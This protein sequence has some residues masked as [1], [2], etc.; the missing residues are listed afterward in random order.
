MTTDRPPPEKAS[1]EAQETY[2]NSRLTSD[3]DD[4]H[5]LWEVCRIRLEQQRFD[6]VLNSVA[7]LEQKPHVHRGT[8]GLKGQALFAMK[9]Y[10]EAKAPL[11]AATQ[12]SGHIDGGALAAAAELCAAA[13]DE[14]LRDLENAGQY[15]A[16]STIARNAKLPAVQAT[17]RAAQ[18]AVA[19]ARGNFEFAI[20]ENKSAIEKAQ[21]SQKQEYERR[22]AL[23]EQKQVFVLPE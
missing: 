12:E 23:Y 17:A 1:L 10:A 2:W 7:V 21:G 16:N 9:R 22:R 3:P 13:P 5:A 14:S 15:A 18:A 6:E 20:Q 4:H 11:L 19:A 8:A